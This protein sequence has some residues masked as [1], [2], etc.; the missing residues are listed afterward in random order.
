MNKPE[1]MLEN[2]THKVLEG[3]ERETDQLI[4]PRRLDLVLINEKKKELVFSWILL[5]RPTIEWKWNKAK[6]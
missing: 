6:R 2:E 3:F 4:L 1:S 5:F